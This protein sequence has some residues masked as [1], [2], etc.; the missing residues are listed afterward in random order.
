MVERM[1]DQVK[2]ENLERVAKLI[3]DNLGYK[4]ERK[5]VW[6]SDE[7][8]GRLDLAGLS[9]GFNAYI[10]LE[11]EQAGGYHIR[12]A[13][14]GAVRVVVTNDG[15]GRGDRFKKWSLLNNLDFA[16]IT[17][18]RKTKA[19]LDKVKELV[20]ITTAAIERYEASID[21]AQRDKEYMAEWAESE[22]PDGFKLEDRWDG[23]YLVPVEENEDSPFKIQVVVVSDQRA[24]QL[25]N[26]SHIRLGKFEFVHVHKIDG[27]K[28][29]EFMRLYRKLYEFT[30]SCDK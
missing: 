6:Q 28:V 8:I 12:M 19:F 4:V 29:N 14:T 2:A 9:K 27:D 20:E 21:Q 24:E 7:H 30:K 25:G 11:D 17:L 15:F 10:V 13:Y 22:I 18:D 23:E 5:K 1:T 16:N 3:E 26:Q